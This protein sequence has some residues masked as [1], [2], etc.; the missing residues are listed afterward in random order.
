MVTLTDQEYNNLQEAAT[1][2]KYLR[3][4]PVIAVAIGVGALIQSHKHLQRTKAIQEAIIPQSTTT[5][6]IAA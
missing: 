2:N 5:T 1:A 3:W 4:I 6:T